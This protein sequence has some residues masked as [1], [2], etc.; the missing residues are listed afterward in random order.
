[1][2]FAF[3]TTFKLIMASIVLI[4]CMTAVWMPFVGIL[5]I[6]A[7]LITAGYL[8]VLGIPVFLILRALGKLNGLSL[9]SAGFLCG[10]MP[11]TILSLRA[12]Y[13]QSSSIEV[14]RV[15]VFY[16]AIGLVSALIFGTIWNLLSVEQDRFPWLPRVRQS[17]EAAD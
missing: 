13:P 15:L 10:G 4:T 9:A 3:H 14:M 8:V 16:G 2:K 11:L 5:A 1:M 7:T 6:Y 17:Q 12:A